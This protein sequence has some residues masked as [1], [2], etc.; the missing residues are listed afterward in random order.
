MERRHCTAVAQRLAVICG[1]VPILLPSFSEKWQGSRM[2]P[3]EI[4]KGPIMGVSETK[5]VILVQLILLSSSSG[6][7]PPNATAQEN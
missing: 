1:L 7:S 6:V 5:R 3:Q 2:T 4:A